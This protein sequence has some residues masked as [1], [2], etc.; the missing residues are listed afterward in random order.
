MSE[1][2]KR[3]APYLLGGF[4]AVAGHAYLN[5]DSE[6]VSEKSE[7][8]T[9]IKTGVCEKT[10]GVLYADYCEPEAGR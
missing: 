1:R 8:Y 10:S 2:L 3:I 4:V 5:R 9:G 6:A 7:I